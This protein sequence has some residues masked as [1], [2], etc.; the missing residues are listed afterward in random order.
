MKSESKVAPPSTF[1][2]TV[3]CLSLIRCP[4][5]ISCYST[6]CTKALD[7]LDKMEKSQVKNWPTIF[8]FRAN[9]DSHLLRNYFCSK[10]KILMDTCQTLLQ[11]QC[12]IFVRCRLVQRNFFENVPESYKNIGISTQK[13]VPALIIWIFPPKIDVNFTFTLCRIFK[14]LLR[15]MGGP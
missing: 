6:T 3:I 13:S 7:R 12:V 5:H 15:L 8:E 10:E 1:Q 9:F 2:M 11:S 14:S 4:F